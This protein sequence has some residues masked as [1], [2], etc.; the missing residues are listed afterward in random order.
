MAIASIL[1]L[2]QNGVTEE[3]FEKN[4]K[5]Q[6]IQKKMLDSLEVSDE[7]IEAG[8]ANA[9]KEIHARHILVEDEKT[10]NE[11]RK[12]L[13]AGGDFEKLAKEHSTERNRTGN[14][15]RPWLVRYW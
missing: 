2:I 4:V 5:A 3:F 1:Y 7:E 12:E 6:M 8:L 10:A 9:K 11:V 14:R 13:E 15:R